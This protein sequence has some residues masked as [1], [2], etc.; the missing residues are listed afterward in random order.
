MPQP[1]CRF[2]VCLALATMLI[3]CGPGET[4]PRTIEVTG[5]V[6]LDGQPVEAATVS[7]IS[8]SGG[9]AGITDANG[10]F[11][12][13]NGA[14]PGRYDVTV[15]KMAG[16]SLRPPATSGGPP[17]GEPPKSLLPER[18]IS[19]KNSGLSAEVTADGGNEFEVRLQK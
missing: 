19:P 7:F 15:T 12:L 2:A 10:R 5:V 9:S 16:G 4:R 6:T 14:A 8:A 11:S 3:G 17:T 1:S 13:V 18:Y